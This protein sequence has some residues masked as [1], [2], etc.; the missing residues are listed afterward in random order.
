[1]RIWI[2]EYGY[3]TNPPDRLFGVSFKT[4]AAYLKQAYGI[5]RSN[6]RIDLMCWFLLRDEKDVSRWQSGLIT[7]G[8]AHKPSFAAYKNLSN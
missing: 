4:Q 6:S 5:A 2:T 8:G 7:A 1:M 3:Q